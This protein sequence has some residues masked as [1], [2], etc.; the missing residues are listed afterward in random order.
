MLDSVQFSPP[1]A[2]YASSILMIMCYGRKSRQHSAFRNTGL[3]IT[4]CCRYQKHDEHGVEL[5]L[6]VEFEA[7]G[8]QKIYDRCAKACEET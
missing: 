8:G 5:D 4:H 1:S 7:S 3:D 6:E 2:L